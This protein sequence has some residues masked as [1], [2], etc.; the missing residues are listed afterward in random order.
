MTTTTT[1]RRWWAADLCE[2]SGA[3]PW[4]EILG[5][6]TPVNPLTV[7][8]WRALSAVL[9]RH[10]YGARSVWCFNCRAITGGSK[11]SLHSYGIATD[12]DPADNPYLKTFRFSWEQTRFTE[13]MITDIERIRSRTGATVFTWGGRWRT[14][15]DYM[16][17]QIDCRPED[18]AAGI[19]WTT[20]SGGELEEIDMRY[21][22]RGGEGPGVTELQR[23]LVMLGHD[24]RFGSPPGGGPDGDGV[25]GRF[26][27]LTA[28]AVAA[29]QRKA[30]AAGVALGD[31]TGDV[32]GPNT[33]AWL[34]RRLASP[35]T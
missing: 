14:V 23:V 28:A 30:S 26:G 5:R 29:E 13:A 3:F 19:D 21:V 34:T 31:E 9:E 12:I 27:E 25:D 16:H 35:A 4:I 18:L 24:L 10:G 7:D 20:V 33:W 17:F 1:L 11:P 2:K 8:A 15:K 22:R 6:R 32:A